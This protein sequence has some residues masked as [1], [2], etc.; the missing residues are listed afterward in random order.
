MS[1]VADTTTDQGNKAAPQPKLRKSLN[2][3]Q[4][5]TAAL[6]VAPTLVL[7]GIVIVF[8][9]VKAI[10]MSFQKDAGLDKATGQFVSGGNAGLSNYKHWLLQECGNVKCPPGTLGSQFYDALW[11]T[12]FFT[13]TTVVIEVVLGLWFAMIM[14]RTFKGRGLVRAAILIP[15]AIPTAVTAKLWFFI[16]SF[17]GIANK[18][19]GVVGIKPLLWTGDKWPARFAIVIADVWKT[20]PFMAL[21]ILAGLQIIGADVYEAAKI[22]GASKWQTFTRITIPMI[23]VPLMVAVLFRTLDVLRIY[24]L[25]AILTNGGGGSGH[26][27]TSLSILVI[28]QIRAGF[29]SASAL[30]TIVFLI[31]AFTAFLFV[32]YGGADVVKRPPRTPQPKRKRRGRGD[33][34]AEAT[35]NVAG[36]SGTVR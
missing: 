7:L 12:L 31:I 9:L 20:T 29:N 24:D 16:L 6:L 14:N 34:S 5:R 8:P 21:L 30:S 33:G 35:A 13:V 26:A 36:T 18:L 1:T 32:K 27:T 3:G 22:D 10:I 11:V 19:L 25:P 2:A 23:K 4:S 15:W 17:D 28:N